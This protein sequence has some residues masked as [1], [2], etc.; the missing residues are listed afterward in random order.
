MS[1][2]FND[3][4]FTIDLVLEACRRTVLKTGQPRFDYADGILEK[5]H[6]SGV[7]SMADVERL[8]A[9]HKSEQKKKEPRPAK[10]ASNRFNNF[11]QREYDYDK[12]E[13]QLLSQ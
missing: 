8:D 6:K 10:S 2:W 7:T 5:W 11:T 12:L 13:K 1:R 9:Q 3:F 4:G